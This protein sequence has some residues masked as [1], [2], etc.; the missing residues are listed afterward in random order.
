MDR[1]RSP[2]P[3]L[4]AVTGR[5]LAL[6][7]IERWLEPATASPSYYLESLRRA[8]AFAAVLGPEPLDDAGAAAMIGRFDGLV[9]TGGIDVDP[10]RYG[11]E[12]APQTYGCDD[13]T[14]AFEVALVG[15]AL[16]AGCPVLAIC[17][18]IQVLNVALGGTL[19]Q[20]ITDWPG[21]EAH[22]LPNGG[23][24]ADVC[25]EI[26]AGTHLAEALGGRATGRCHHHQAIDRLGRDL[27]VSATALDGIIEG[28]ERVGRPWVVGVQW[29]PEDSADRDPQQQ[30][31][32]DRFIAEA[33]AYRKGARPA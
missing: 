29:H 6:G 13:L 23:G 20:H 12:R 17:R 1:R 19:D 25:V 18:G 24:G 26:V 30:A 27:R 2:D 28:I 21:I 5:N 8:G 4:I 10:A 3:S 14:D 15:A 31:L 7:R 32:F 33:E 16:D 22:G 11:A 9:L